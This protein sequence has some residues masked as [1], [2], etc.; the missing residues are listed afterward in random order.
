MKYALA[1]LITLTSVMLLSSSVADPKPPPATHVVK[2]KKAQP[3]IFSNKAKSPKC[4]DKI[5]VQQRDIADE[6][7]K[8]KGM[9]KKEKR[10]RR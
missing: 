9:L 10:T 7:H 6:L 2:A 4:I 8:I 3:E 5:Q 1:L